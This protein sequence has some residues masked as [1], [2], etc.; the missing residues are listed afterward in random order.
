MRLS[1]H[2]DKN[3]Q[4]MPK[5][6]Y[7]NT[8]G[9]LLSCLP[10]CVASTSISDAQPRL[11]T[12]DSNNWSR[13]RIDGMR[14]PPSPALCCLSRGESSISVRSRCFQRWQASSYRGHE[15]TSLC[16]RTNVSCQAKRGSVRCPCPP[17]P[18]WADRVSSSSSISD[19]RRNSF[20]LHFKVTPY[21]IIFKY[22]TRG[23]F[24]STPWAVRDAARVIL[25]RRTHEWSGISLLSASP[26]EDLV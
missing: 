8:A 24:I 20:R 13:G 2:E 3:L 1:R 7:C 14:K 26:A 22:P 17:A 15:S 6:N 9:L 4:R 10:K 16:D 19:K 12:C 11:E 21:Y 23:Y 5:G 25:E 18:R